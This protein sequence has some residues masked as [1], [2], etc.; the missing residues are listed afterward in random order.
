MTKKNIKSLHIDIL[1]F[2]FKYG[3]PVDSN[4]VFD[5]RFMPNPFY[6]KKLQH[7]TGLNKKVR[8]FV[9]NFS[10][11]ANFLKKLYALHDFLLPFYIKEKKSRLKISIGCTGGRHRSVVIAKELG[12]HLKKQHYNVKI[13]HRDIEK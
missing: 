12:E 8:D 5:V 2:G 6:D 4:I 1:S 10:A 7:L 13:E 9:L 11:V 3:S